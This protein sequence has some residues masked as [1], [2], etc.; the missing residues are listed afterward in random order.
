MPTGNTAPPSVPAAGNGSEGRRCKCLSLGYNVP[1]DQ[2]AGRQAEAGV[3]VTGAAESDEELLRRIAGGDRLAMRVLFA[4][5]H[6][7]VHRFICG[8]LRSDAGADDVLNDVFF[9]VWQQAGRFEGRSSVST[10]LLGV[11]RYKALSARRKRSDD[12]LDDELAGAVADEADDPEVIVQKKSKGE[13]LRACLA[14]LSNEHRSVIDL[15]YYH[16]KSIEDV[17]QIM[18]VPVNTI[19]TRMFYA[20]RKLSELLAAAGID[21]GW[22]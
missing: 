18:A 19:K 12:P 8:L 20:R 11:A 21:R 4:R 5:H 7:R 14:G 22:P 2:R 17:A 10:W 1:P 13:A 16:E 6:M 15:V 3:P 9:D